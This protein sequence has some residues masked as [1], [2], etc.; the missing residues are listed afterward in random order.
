ML[1]VLLIAFFSLCVPVLA[2]QNSDT[3]K[4]LSEDGETYLCKD[5]KPADWDRFLDQKLNVLVTH[6]NLQLWLSS[7]VYDLKDMKKA[8]A[9]NI[10]SQHLEPCLDRILGYNSQFNSSPDKMFTGRMSDRKYLE[11]QPKDVMTLPSELMSSS[12]A[13]PKNW[14]ELFKKKSWKYALFQ[15]NT[16]NTGRLIVLIPG[17]KYDRLLVYVGVGNPPS[18]DPTKYEHLQMQAIEKRPAQ[19]TRLA[20]YYFR[21][22]GFTGPNETA[23]INSFGG[24]CVSCHMSGPRAIELRSSTAFPTELGGVDSIEQ[25]NRLIVREDSLDYTPYYD[26]KYFPEHLK[27]GE[28]K[29]T[30]CHDGEKRHSLA[31]S[32]N[33]LGEFEEDSIHRKV[34]LEKSMPIF[35]GDVISDEDRE[36]LFA[37]VGSD[38][39][40]KMKSWLAETKCSSIK[41]PDAPRTKS[42]TTTSPARSVN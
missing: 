40:A 28:G 20:K 7:L 26:P 6:P 1:V 37:F 21:T 14:R 25:L 5:W 23:Q 18:G 9:N 22:W 11:M 16:A 2:Q 13:L 35:D 3:V 42:R 30:G 32:V 33:A 27:V 24:R 10:S 8:C 38:Y 4:A 36:K 41:Q 29:C 39:R 15:S 17:E 31:Y 34:I 19:P 12:H